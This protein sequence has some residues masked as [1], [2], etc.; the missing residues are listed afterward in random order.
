V[1]QQTRYHKNPEAVSRLDPE[2]YRVTQQDDAELPF[3]NAY[4][5]DTNTD[6][7]DK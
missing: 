7:D 6:S 5:S 3:A 2:Q 1:T 4:W